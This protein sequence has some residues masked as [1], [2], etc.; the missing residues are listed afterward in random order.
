MAGRQRL[1]PTPAV[2]VTGS[3]CPLDMPVFMVSTP[4][5]TGM[6]SP[7]EN[8]TPNPALAV[9]GPQCECLTF[10]VMAR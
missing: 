2:M 6:L 4:N 5:M 8:S 3:H 10:E 9:V 7:T 1:P